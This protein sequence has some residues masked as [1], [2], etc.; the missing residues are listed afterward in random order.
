MRQFFKS[1]KCVVNKRKDIDTNKN[2]LFVRDLEQ[3]EG[4]AK[5][6]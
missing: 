1:L 3:E 5:F 4:Q 2:N 6:I